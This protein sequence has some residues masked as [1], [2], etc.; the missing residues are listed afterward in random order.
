[1]YINIRLR[2]FILSITRDYDRSPDKNTPLARI[3]RRHVTTC[4]NGTGGGATS[5]GCHLIVAIG[6]AL[7][8]R[9]LVI[10][11]ASLVTTELE[12]EPF[13]LALC[14]SHTPTDASYPL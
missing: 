6:L 5:S 1:M 8:V 7:V 14:L 12:R 13:S 4:A 10:P 9:E 11:P 2:T 3:S